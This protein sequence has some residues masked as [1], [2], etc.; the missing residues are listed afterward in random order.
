MVH[1]PPPDP[2]IELVV[3]SRGI[4]KGLVQ[5]DGVQ[6]FGRAF[7]AFGRLQ[8]GGQIKNVTST[9]S[10]GEGWAFATMGFRL[11]HSDLVLGA[12]YKFQT[13]ANRAID[14]TALELTAGASRKFGHAGVKISLAYSPDDLGATGRSWYLEGGPAVDVAKATSLSAYVGRRERSGG[15]DYTAFNFGITQRLLPALSADLRYYDT[16]ESPLGN[17][18][19]SRVVVSL[20]AKL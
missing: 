4:S 9:T 8:I 11:W 10:N 7:L 18:Y 3:A 17:P 13:G 2:G 15:P 6:A 16:A 19:A 5:T 14:R 1:L 20:R 12:A